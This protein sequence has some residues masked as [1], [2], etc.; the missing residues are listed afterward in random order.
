M[1]FGYGSFV[2]ARQAKEMKEYEITKPILISFDQIDNWNDPVVRTALR[3]IN[4][5]T[6]VAAIRGLGRN[7]IEEIIGNLPH[8]TAAEV[9]RL[10]DADKKEENPFSCWQDTKSEREKIVK[11]IMSVKK[12]LR[13][14][15]WRLKFLRTEPVSKPC[16]FFHWLWSFTSRLI[17]CFAFMM[18]II[19]L[20]ICHIISGQLFF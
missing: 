5:Q 17:C 12:S 8:H 7:S 18:L 6:I 1:Q 14:G 10:I 4:C 3:K 13:E 9:I 16:W 11:S 2:Y 19:P 15:E 20:L